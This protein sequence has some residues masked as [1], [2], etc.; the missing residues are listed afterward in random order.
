MTQPGWRAFSHEGTRSRPGRATLVAGSRRWPGADMGGR[1]V[2]RLH[3]GHHA[4]SEGYAHVVVAARVVLD[5]EPARH[6]LGQADG[7]QL[8]QAGVV[9]EGQAVISEPSRSLSAIA[10]LA[11]PGAEVPHLLQCPC[12]VHRDPVLCSW[13]GCGPDVLL[14]ETTKPGPSNKGSIL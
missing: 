1:A 14:P 9:V 7:G 2:H 5:P 4:E 12:G 13:T 8:E 11:S 10:R 3:Q 6:R